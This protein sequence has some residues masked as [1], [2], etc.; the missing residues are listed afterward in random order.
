MS[1]SAVDVITTKRDGGRLSD[2]QVDWVVADEQMSSLAM[3]IL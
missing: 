1:L 2:E 3:A